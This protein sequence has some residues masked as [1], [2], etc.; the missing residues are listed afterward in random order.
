MF[1]KDWRPRWDNDWRAWIDEQYGTVE[2]A[3]RDWEFK[4]PRD[5]QGQ[6]VAP[7]EKYFRV[8]GPWRT[9]MAAYRRFMDDLMSRQWNQAN[10]TLREIDPNHL[11]SF[12][13]GNTL[14]HDFTFTATPKHIDFICPEGYA[15]P[16]SED[17]YFVAGF[18]TKYVHFT[19]R[20]KPIIWSEFGQSV[21]DAATMD[22][23]ARAR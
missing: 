6:T 7:P 16:H 13:Q 11:I 12:R 17:G 10:R 8:D 22:Y 1:G 3:E 14:P 18:I 19:T 23:S 2:A 20:G 21:W 9:L 5:E 15:I 4:A